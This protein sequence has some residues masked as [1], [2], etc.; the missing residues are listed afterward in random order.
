MVANR[1]P[2]SIRVTEFISASVYFMDEEEMP[3]RF[4]FDPL[5]FSVEH[6]FVNDKV[7]R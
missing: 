2:A 7:H 4:F 1:A 3:Y 5:S 6:R